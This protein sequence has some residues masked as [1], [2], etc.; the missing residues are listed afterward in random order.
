MLDVHG[1]N[2]SS[3]REKRSPRADGTLLNGW[4]QQQVDTPY[5]RV[6]SR[7]RGNNLHLLLEGT[8]CPSGAVVIP[9]LIQALSAAALADQ[10]PP[11]SPPVYRVIVYGRL[12]Q[13]S[14]PEWTESFVPHAA[15]RPS[16]EP[17]PLETPRSPEQTRPRSLSELAGSASQEC[18]IEATGVS[19]LHAARQGQPEA[20]ARHLSD[21]FG[22]LGIAVRIRQG[23]PKPSQPAAS[24]TPVQ[25]NAHVEAH[26]SLPTP[27]SPQRLF[28]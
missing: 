8:P 20:I 24:S 3:A 2:P 17:A 28:I 14:T 19:M 23:S 11:E 22:S 21:V 16:L 25:L 15:D 10:L 13:C 12:P 5:V 7:L 9:K 26:S 4:I 6:K 1:Q 18:N 27:P